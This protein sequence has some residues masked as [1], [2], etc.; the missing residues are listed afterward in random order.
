MSFKSKSY[1]IVSHTFVEGSSQV[2]L[3]FLN[4]HKSNSVAF[5]GHPLNYAPDVANFYEYYSKGRKIKLRKFLNVKLPEKLSYFKDFFMTFISFSFLKKRFDIYFGYDALNAF[6]G[7][8]LRRIGLVKQVVFYTIDYFPQRFNSKFFNW[9]YHKIDSYCAEKSDFV[10]NL[11]SNIGKARKKKGVKKKPLVVP[12]GIEI[13]K[14]NVRKY[15]KHHLIYVGGLEWYYG[16]QLVIQGM[17]KLLKKFPK[18]YLTIIG[19]PSAVGYDKEL[20]KMVKELSLESK[21]KFLGS[22]TNQKKLNSILSKAGIGLA[23]YLPDDKGWKKYTDVTKPKTYLA[24]GLPVLITS[25]L[26]ISKEISDSNLGIVVKPNLS[27]VINGIEKFFNSDVE[28]LNK[29]VL[30]FRENYDYNKI[31]NKNLQRCFD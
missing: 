30:E 11:S 5:I 1:V 8:I 16:V 17:P 10:W 7:L 14:I 18:L 19:P 12:V 27:G 21:V 23:L 20:K 4:K 26:S 29:N 2:L 24:A 15:D 13:H 25:Y 31:F 22:I 9:L 3:K 6:A 28:Q